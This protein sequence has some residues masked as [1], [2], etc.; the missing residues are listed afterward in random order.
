MDGI[1]QLQTLP[2]L[3]LQRAWEPG[4]RKT[5]LTLFF[6]TIT[7]QKTPSEISLGDEHQHQPSWKIPVHKLLQV[8]A[9]AA[10]L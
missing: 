7:V 10:P 5:E 2:R 1:S 3:S 6:P 4:R 8:S 9:A